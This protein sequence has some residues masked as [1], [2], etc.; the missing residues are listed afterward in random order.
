MRKFVLTAIVAAFALTS[1]N[2]GEKT[3]APA[4][5]P[6]KEQ[7]PA[8]GSS[9]GIKAEK[10]LVPLSK[11]EKK[12]LELYKEV[13]LLV[14]PCEECSGRRGLFGRKVAKRPVVLVK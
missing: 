6:A 12:N 8:K 9:D 1:V 7:A 2:A 10:G 3:Q 13:E 5:V 4:K 11:S 14:V